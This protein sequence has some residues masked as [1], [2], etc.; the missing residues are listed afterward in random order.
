MHVLTLIT[1]LCYQ[2]GR[3]LT[4]VTVLTGSVVRVWGT[5][6]AV[7]SRHEHKLSRVDK[8]M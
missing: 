4:Q 3:R 7:L 1:A 8:A 6:E 5:L 2:I